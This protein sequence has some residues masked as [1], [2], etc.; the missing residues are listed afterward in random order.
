MEL[1]FGPTSDA[2]TNHALR[3][4]TTCAEVPH[5]EVLFFT[6]AAHLHAAQFTG[7][8]D[9][10]ALQEYPNPAEPVPKRNLTWDR[11]GS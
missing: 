5:G 1:R 11:R 6:S 4:H 9:L 8:F 7:S 10:V 3:T 2:R